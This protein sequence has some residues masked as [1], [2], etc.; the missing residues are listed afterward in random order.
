MN[1]TAQITPYTG[2]STAPASAAPT[3]K[4]AT[5]KAHNQPAGHYIAPQPTA[6]NAIKE[7]QLAIMSVYDA[8]KYYP[9]FNN[10]PGYRE[11]DMGSGNYSE[12]FEHGSDAFLTF[13]L[14]RY[15]NKSPILGQQPNDATK[16]R[17]THVGL[18][19]NLIKLIESLKVVGKNANQEPAPTGVWDTATNNA[20]KNLYAITYA[21]FNLMNRLN[22][23]Q[24]DYSASNLDEFR[25]LIPVNANSIMNKIGSAK[26]ITRNL[27]SVKKLIGDFMSAMNKERGKYNAYIRQEKP[28]NTKFGDKALTKYDDN[29]QVV[30]D[31]LKSN[32]IPL[33]TMPKD[34]GTNE[35][36]IPLMTSYLASKTNFDDFVKKYE[37]TFNG[38]DPL[39]D[40]SARNELLGFIESKI[41]SMNTSEPKPAAPIQ[42]N[43]SDPGY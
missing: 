38:Y 7:M 28:F 27:A 9:M 17:Q 34:P 2:E 26:H 36:D 13:L 21:M 1:K 33:F 41:K 30:F 19:D 6:N 10:E 39:T 31:A 23:T 29:D 22:I 4:P 40:Q 42:P 16:G 32:Q 37:I 14:N 15:V 5:P 11:N 8:F 25:K 3:A 35:G 20:L 43:R 12:S 18:P 24:H